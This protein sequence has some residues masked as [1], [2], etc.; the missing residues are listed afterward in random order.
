MTDDR[1]NNGRD[2]G[3]RFG[4]GNP[5]R[6]KGSRNQ[7][8]RLAEKL[9][10]DDA[11]GVVSAVLTA[12]KSGDMA[13]ARIVLDRL[14]PARRDNSVTFPLPAIETAGDASRAMGAILQ[15]VAAGDVTPGEG[16]AVAKL[17]ET[18]LRAI[19]AT[20]FEARLAALE[21]ARAE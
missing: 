7:V 8:T 13:A 17:I 3:G 4:P 10:A 9:M 5:G 2:T 21:N 15:A 11:E 16:E 18:Y 12:A 20:E 1:R 19:E 14:Y 6:P